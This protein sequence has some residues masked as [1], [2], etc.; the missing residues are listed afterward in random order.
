MD[1]RKYDYVLYKLIN[2]IPFFLKDP[3]FCYLGEKQ[4]AY[5]KISATAL[6]WSTKSLDQAQAQATLLTALGEGLMEILK[7]EYV[8]TLDDIAEWL[9]T[10]NQA[11]SH[12]GEIQT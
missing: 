12:G 11:A 5:I 10:I 7:I 6:V 2:G 8:Y 3:L 4:P 9:K 1:K